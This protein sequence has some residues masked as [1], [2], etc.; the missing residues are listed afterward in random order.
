MTAR[1][2]ALCGKNT[3]GCSGRGE[4][5]TGKLLQHKEETLGWMFVRRMVM[6]GYILSAVMQKA[7]QHLKEDTDSDRD[8]WWVTKGE[9]GWG[10]IFSFEPNW[11]HCEAASLEWSRY[12]LTWWGA[13]TALQ[14][15]APKCDF[16][17]VHSS[18]CEARKEQNMSSKEMSLH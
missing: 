17:I 7:I 3:N 1:I 2:S 6:E 14:N 12:K 5:S 18:S 13:R 10:L 8:C 9:Q 15:R 16:F 11:R 4:D